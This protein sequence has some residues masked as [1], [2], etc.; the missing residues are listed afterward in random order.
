M[1]APQVYWATVLNFSN[2]VELIFTAI[3]LEYGKSHKTKLGP[4]RPL[5]SYYGRHQEGISDLE[6]NSAVRGR[7]KM[8]GKT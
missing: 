6:R 2:S 8:H 5:I 7:N 1:V 4:K 3:S